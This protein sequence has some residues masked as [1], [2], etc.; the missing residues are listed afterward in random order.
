MKHRRGIWDAL[1]DSSSRSIGGGP[2]ISPTGLL[3]ILTFLTMAATP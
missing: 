2:D 1:A 3:G